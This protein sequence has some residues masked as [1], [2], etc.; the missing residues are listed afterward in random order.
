MVVLYS[1]SYSRQ[2]AEEYRRNPAFN[3]VFHT[4]IRQAAEGYRRERSSNIVIH[5]NVRQAAVG[6]RRKRLVA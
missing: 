5:K 2:A 4:G 1:N 6:Y 3:I